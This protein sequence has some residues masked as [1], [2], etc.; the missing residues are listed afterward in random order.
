MYI[1]TLSMY[2]IH[3][4]YHI[5]ITVQDYQEN[6]KE[7]KKI[8]LVGEG[9]VL[10]WGKIIHTDLIHVSRKVVFMIGKFWQSWEILKYLNCIGRK[11]FVYLK[12]L[13]ADW[14]SL[15]VLRNIKMSEL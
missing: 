13:K 12:L 8:S 7:D 9:R 4:V 6:E 2:N 1:C 10:H 14:K 15:T 11:W 3:I 5:I